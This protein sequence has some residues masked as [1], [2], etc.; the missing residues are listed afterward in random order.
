[1]EL[2]DALI[3]A[4]MLDFKVETET[5]NVSD[6][7]GAHRQIAGRRHVRLVIELEHRTAEELN[8]LVQSLQENGNRLVVL[9]DGSPIMH[10]S[11]RDKPMTPIEATPKTDKPHYMDAFW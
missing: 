5:H 2:R 1:M 6:G 8:W 9:P 7:F 3:P 4:R 10:P 11:K